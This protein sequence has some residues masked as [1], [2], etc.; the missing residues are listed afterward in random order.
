[1]AVKTQETA[2]A[3]TKKMPVQ[4]PPRQSFS[5][6]NRLYTRGGRIRHEVPTHLFSQDGT[7]QSIQG[8][9]GH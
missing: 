6:L 2:G 5:E 9:G 7:I 1:M 8:L 3:K 4:E